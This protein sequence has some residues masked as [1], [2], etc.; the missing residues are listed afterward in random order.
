MLF[1]IA[2]TAEQTKKQAAE[3]ARYN[4]KLSDMKESINSK[5]LR[6]PIVVELLIFY[7]F[8]ILYHYCF[9][10]PGD[11]ELH[12]L[13]GHLLSGESEGARH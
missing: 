1:S 2:E 13:E 8:L 5:P 7:S 10:F 9:L 3:V 6:K 11:D 12:T 4:V